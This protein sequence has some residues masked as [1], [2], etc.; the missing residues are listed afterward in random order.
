MTD[1]RMVHPGPLPRERR[2]ARDAAVCLRPAT[3]EDAERLT[4]LLAEAFAPDP[5]DGAR[6]RREL[7]DPPEVV[8]I[9]LADRDGEPMGTA[10]EKVLTDGTSPYGYL[11]WVATS[12][13]ARGLGIGGAVTSAVLVGFAEAGLAHAVLDT[14]DARIPALGMYLGFGFRPDPR[15]AEEEAAW[16]GVLRALDL[17]AVPV[18]RAPGHAYGRADG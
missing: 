8:R 4:G 12:A 18:R 3:E 1:L 13:R 14:D 5:W 15:T 2:P 10:S 9:W 6:T 17:P 11:H 16:A 7:L